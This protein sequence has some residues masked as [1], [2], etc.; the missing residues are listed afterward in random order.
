ML[1]IPLLASVPKRLMSADEVEVE[2]KRLR[3]R[4]TSKQG[5]T[6]A[7]LTREG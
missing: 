5:L 3:V 7:R 2:G 4:R 1:D 6:T